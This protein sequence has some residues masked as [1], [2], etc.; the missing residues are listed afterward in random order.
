MAEAFAARIPRTRAYREERN[1]CW[2]WIGEAF[3]RAGDP[4]GAER[5]V[6]SMDDTEME[7]ELR[8][9][10]VREGLGLGLQEFSGRMLRDILENM[11]RLDPWLAQGD[12]RDLLMAAQVLLGHTAAGPAAPPEEP[13]APRLERFLLYGH[14]DLKVL[15]LVEQ[16][17]GGG[18]TD[19]GLERQMD[20]DAFQRIEPARQPG[21]DSDPTGL[22]AEAFAA[23]LFDRPVPRDPRDDKLLRGR[24]SVWVRRDDTGLLR[25]ATDLFLN[26]PARTAPYSAA[27]VE[28]GLWLLLGHPLC[29][30]R[31]PAPAWS[32]RS[33][34]WRPCSCRF[35]T[36][37]STRLPTLVRPF[38]CGGT[39][40]LWYRRRQRKR[41]GWGCW[42][43]SWD[44][45]P[46]P[47]RSRRYMVC[48]K[49]AV[50]ARWSWPEVSWSN[51]RSGSRRSNRGRWPACIIVPACYS[52]GKVPHRPYRSEWHG[53]RGV[54]SWKP[55]ARKGGK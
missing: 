24:T 22:S 20:S 37:T 9:G 15:W 50:H 23:F 51:T 14:T 52:Q 33:P 30:W 35:A 6:R 2:Q 53:W 42:N 5:A 8:C 10:L 32:T 21:T 49:P 55:A 27:Q 3:L 41:R 19:P 36:T 54:P 31:P 43:A 45:R 40:P 39:R 25:Q 34:A 7:A 28:R 12:Y 13:P 4:A 47:A 29:P 44:W 18:V 48:S 11:D 1:Q 38:S 17:A 46:G 26:F 16:A